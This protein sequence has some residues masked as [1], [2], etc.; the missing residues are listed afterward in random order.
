M[1]LVIG[2]YVR[3]GIVMAA[4][5][6]LSLQIPL[7]R[8]EGPPRTISVTGSDS[9]K[10]L[11][12]APNNVGIATYG[13]ADIGGAPVPGFVELFVIEKLKGRDLGPA[14]VADELS[15]YFAGLGVR[16]GTM[17]HV[18]GYARGP[19]GLEQEYHSVDP[20]KRIVSKLNPVG[21]PGANWGGE[22]DVLQRLLNEVVLTQPDGAST[23]LPHFGL[24]FQVLHPAGR[25]RFCGVAEKAIEVSRAPIGTGGAYD[26][27]DNQAFRS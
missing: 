26:D 8:P 5:S 23:K 10:K 21:Q 6:R 18:A 2:V 1:S 15:S 12:L 22:I 27:Q 9:A 19:G 11:F 3:E 7:A 4:D 24:P 14:Q 13:Q 16:P 25:D 17:F 20:A